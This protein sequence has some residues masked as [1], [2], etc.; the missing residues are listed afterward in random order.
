MM[1]DR[2]T[3]HMSLKDHTEH[4][5]TPLVTPSPKNFD[6]EISQL[7]NALDCYCMACGEHFFAEKPR[8]VCRECV[9]D[10]YTD[11]RPP[12]PIDHPN[13]E[14]PAGDGKTSGDEGTDG[15]TRPEIPGGLQRE[16]VALPVPDTPPAPEGANVH[17]IGP[18]TDADTLDLQVSEAQETFDKYSAAAKTA[19]RDAMEEAWEQGYQARKREEVETSTPEGVPPRGG[20]SFNE[21]IRALINCASRENMSDTPD[22]ILA[23]AMEDFLL[24]VEQV[25]KRRRK[26]HG[27]K[28]S[29]P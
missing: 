29:N 7:G 3:I 21:G 24:L 14:T 20:D 11:E 2:K 4:S 22:F 15:N 18:D 5:K 16:T 8:R 19:L 17:G 25:I 10:G 13:L 6:N 9:G 26:W 27:Q 12:D 28:T 1:T 23:D